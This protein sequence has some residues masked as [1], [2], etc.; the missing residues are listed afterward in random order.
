MSN[1]DLLRPVILYVLG[2]DDFWM[3]LIMVAIFAVPLIFK[4][5]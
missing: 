1:L 5:H 2:L 4:K 3:M